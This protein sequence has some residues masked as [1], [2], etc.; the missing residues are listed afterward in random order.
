MN[1]IKIYQLLNSSFQSII[2]EYNSLQYFYN[3]ISRF[4]IIR[5]NVLLIPYNSPFNLEMETNVTV[6]QMLNYFKENEHLLGDTNMW[7]C[8]SYNRN[9]KLGGN[10]EVGNMDDELFIIVCQKHIEKQKSIALTI[11]PQNIRFILK[12]HDLFTHIRNKYSLTE[13]Y[14]NWRCYSQDYNQHL[15]PNEKLLDLQMDN[16]I[17]ATDEIY[18][19]KRIQAGLN[20]HL[21]M[22]VQSDSKIIE[23]VRFIQKYLKLQGD[24]QQWTCHSLQL[25]KNLEFNSTVNDIVGEQLLITTTNGIFNTQNLFQTT[26]DTLNYGQSMNQTNQIF[27][28]YDQSQLSVQQLIELKIEILEGVYK[29]SFVDHFNPNTQIE[30]LAIFILNYLSLDMSQVALDLFINGHQYNN[31]RDRVQT[32]YQFGIKSNSIVQAKVRWLD[33]KACLN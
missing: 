15:K 25:N 28:Q 23:I 3:R 20:V 14:Q 24:I 26:F 31:Q 2:D 10:D 12:V 13:N 18:I 17:I 5:K 11:Q 21:A 32:L 22:E 33:T 1:K 27:H 8:Y 29:R 16:F 4:M 7:S 19:Q 6:N 30:K 9:I